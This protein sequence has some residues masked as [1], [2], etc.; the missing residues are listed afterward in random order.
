[1]ILV[2]SE[3]SLYIERGFQALFFQLGICVFIAAAARLWLWIAAVAVVCVVFGFG[4]MV[5]GAVIGTD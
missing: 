5:C 3:V 4:L 2:S 1:M